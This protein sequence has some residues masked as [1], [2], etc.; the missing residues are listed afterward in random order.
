MADKNPL[1]DHPS[2]TNNAEGYFSYQTNPVIEKSVDRGDDPVET[3]LAGD[4]TSK[5]V[6]ELVKAAIP[7]LDRYLLEDDRDMALAAAVSMAIGTYQEGKWQSKIDS[8]TSDI[9]IRELDKKVSKSVEKSVLNGKKSEVMAIETGKTATDV[10][11]VSPSGN[12]QKATPSIIRTKIQEQPSGVRSRVRRMVGKGTPLVVLASVIGRLDK[13]A[14]FLQGREASLAESLDVVSNTLDKFAAEVKPVA[15]IRSKYP[16]LWSFLES[17]TQEEI[18]GDKFAELVKDLK[19]FSGDR[20]VLD[21]FPH[22]S[23][24]NMD[25]IV[26]TLETSSDKKSVLEHLRGVLE[27]K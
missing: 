18:A 6:A 21:S 14:D 9:L 26:S 13:A 11:V 22:L 23:T 3:V 15:Y 4:I 12:L 16:T 27:G 7:F 5:D 24:L 10:Q 17:H 20:K 25:S 1:K 19:K 2:V 8:S